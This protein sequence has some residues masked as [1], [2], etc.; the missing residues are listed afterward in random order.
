M[1]NLAGLKK[2]DGKFMYIDGI[3]N[4]VHSILLA[5]SA[6]LMW[7]IKCTQNFSFLNLK[8]MDLNNFLI[9]F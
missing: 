7:L 4:N 5:N 6:I 1:S 3:F 9:L 2:I 8:F